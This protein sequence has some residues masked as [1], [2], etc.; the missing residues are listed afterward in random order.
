G[1]AEGGKARYGRLSAQAH[2]ARSAARHHSASR[3]LGG[4]AVPAARWED[5]IAVA[6]AN[7]GAPIHPRLDGHQQEGHALT[8]P[9]AERRREPAVTPHGGGENRP[10]REPDC[11]TGAA[12]GLPLEAASASAALRASYSAFF[13]ARRAFWRWRARGSCGDPM[14]ARTLAE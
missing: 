6:P 14:M 3:S 2:P 1:A 7:R 10:Q 11:A 12:L 5:P 4:T 8:H 9:A 13:F